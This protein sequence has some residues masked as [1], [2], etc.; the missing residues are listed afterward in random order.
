MG[1]GHQFHR[2]LKGAGIA[3]AVVGM[4]ML[5]AGCQAPWSDNY[6]PTYSN[7]PSGGSPVV[8]ERVA[9]DTL[10]DEGFG[11]LEGSGGMTFGLRQGN[12]VSLGLGRDHAEV[13]RSTAALARHLEQTNQGTARAACNVH[14]QVNRRGIFEAAAG[15][16]GNVQA[17]REAAAQAATAV[18]QLLAQRCTDGNRLTSTELAEAIWD[19]ELDIEVRAQAGAQVFAPAI[20]LQAEGGWG[21]G[22][23]GWFV[24]VRLFQN[25]E[26][27]SEAMEQ[28]AQEDEF[29]SDIPSGLHD[30]EIWKLQIGT[31]DQACNAV[32]SFGAQLGD[33]SRRNPFV[34][35]ARRVRDRAEDLASA[36][37][38]FCESR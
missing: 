2:G 17:E 12:E 31:H 26:A 6:G 19:S 33:G 8:D 5:V 16:T 32:I 7:P 28:Q 24:R 4:G 10:R 9:F 14:I 36:L 1:F 22:D 38:D 15:G 11:D 27:A 18:A 13:A 25:A 34:P 23:D 37:R 3:I 29:Q 35:R 21:K 30:P 20:I